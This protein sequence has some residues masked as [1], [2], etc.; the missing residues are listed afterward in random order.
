MKR[1]RLLLILL[2]AATGHAAAADQNVSPAEG[3]GQGYRPRSGTWYAAYEEYWKELPAHDGAACRTGAGQSPLLLTRAGARPSGSGPLRFTD[4]GPWRV[5]NEPNAHTVRMDLAT[6]RTASGPESVPRTVAVDGTDYPLAQFHFHHPSEHLLDGV[7]YPMELHLV[8]MHPDG[9]RVGVV[10]AVFLEIAGEDDRIDQ[11]MARWSAFFDRRP[12]E[13][14]RGIAG[15]GALLTSLL[16][17]PDRRAYLRYAGSLTTPGC[18]GGVTW[19]VMTAPV[20][21]A[22]GFVE[23]FRAAFPMNARWPQKANGRTP[24]TGGAAARAR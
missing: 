24:Q 3:E 10:V 14:R 20:K 18:D 16:P 21:V 13:G 8:H 19:L 11:E 7:R 2:L 22:R 12:F 17:P 15:S 4:A 6:E 1:L 5:W 23:D 9:K